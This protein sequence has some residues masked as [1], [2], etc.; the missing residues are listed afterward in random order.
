MAYVLLRKNPGNATSV[1]ATIAGASS[2]TSVY[3]SG[4]IPRPPDTPPQR[5]TPPPQAS[6]AKPAA[7]SHSRSKPQPR[8]TERHR[9]DTGMP[10]TPPGQSLYAS[11]AVHA[12]QD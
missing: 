9:P 10:P 2:D 7:A 8:R 12:I 11:Y 6:A 4:S 1:S 3:R 5:S